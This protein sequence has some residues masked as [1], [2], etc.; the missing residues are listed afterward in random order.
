MIDRIK[1]KQARKS[2]DRNLTQFCERAGISVNVWLSYEDGRRNPPIK[3]VLDLLNGYSIAGF[4]MKRLR[5]FE[6]SDITD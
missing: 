6:E 2:I 3:K 4:K 5:Q 1:L